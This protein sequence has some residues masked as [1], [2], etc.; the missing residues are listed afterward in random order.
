MTAASTSRL[1][2]L[3]LEG[4]EGGDNSFSWRGRGRGATGTAAAIAPTGRRQLS[5]Q[6]RLLKKSKLIWDL[7]VL[8]G[9]MD[10]EGGRKAWEG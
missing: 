7:E 8:V 5:C 10:Q 3:I 1:S 6:T 2:S 4:V 9:T